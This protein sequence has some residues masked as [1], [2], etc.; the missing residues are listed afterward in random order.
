MGRNCGY[1]ALLA[2]LASEADWVMVPEN[3]PKKGW[4]DNMCN[5]LMY[6]RDHGHRLNIVIVSEGAID[7]DGNPITPDYLK[8]VYDLICF[9]FQ[10]ISF[11]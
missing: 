10:C 9:T 5:R 11:I 2:G 6:H 7:Q 8:T 1:L 4:E 3:P